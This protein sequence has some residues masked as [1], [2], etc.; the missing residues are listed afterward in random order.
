MPLMA[1]TLAEMVNTS[2]REGVFPNALKHA[3]VRPRLKK[4]SLDPDDVTHI[5]LSLT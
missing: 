4:Q 2:F 1:G 5:D 3:I